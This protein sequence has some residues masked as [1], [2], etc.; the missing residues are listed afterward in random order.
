MG[1]GGRRDWGGGVALD[2]VGSRVAGTRGGG[3]R[4]QELGPPRGGRLSVFGVYNQVSECRE[5]DTEPRRQ[6][7][8]EGRGR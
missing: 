6:R 2:F 5:R 7:Q 3:R 8:A 1:G 4:G